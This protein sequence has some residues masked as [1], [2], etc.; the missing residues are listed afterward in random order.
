MASWTTDDTDALARCGHCDNCTRPPGTMDQKDVTVEAWQ[1]LKIVAAVQR[2]GGRLTLNGLSDLARGA[3][4]GAF[5]AGGNGKGKAKDKSTLDL[6]EVA[7]GKV[8]FSKDVSGTAACLICSPSY[9]RLFTE[10]GHRNTTGG[11]APFS[12]PGG[13]LFRKLLR[14]Q[15][16]RCPRAAGHTTRPILSRRSGE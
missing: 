13:V 16:L 7:G 14:R 12:L 15:C 4:G 8:G 1:I 11:V 2:Q 6:K 5:D 3:G 10:L 9:D